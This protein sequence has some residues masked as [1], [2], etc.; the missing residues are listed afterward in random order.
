MWR[1]LARR[2]SSPLHDAVG[3]GT[4]A[5]V[6]SM[7]YSKQGSVFARDARGRTPLHL[8]ATTGNETI[9]K[10][11]ISHRADPQAEDADGKTP[12]EVWNG[13]DLKGFAANL[14]KSIEEEKSGARA[15]R[16]TDLVNDPVTGKKI[17]CHIKAPPIKHKVEY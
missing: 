3:T 10:M 4:L 9:C 11:L 16:R 12:L 7:L 15:L 6:R 17:S 1:T 13:G 8:A 5:D 2:F 14:Q